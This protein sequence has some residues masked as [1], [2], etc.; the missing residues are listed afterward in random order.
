M[1]INIYQKRNMWEHARRVACVNKT[2]ILIRPL[3]PLLSV[4][5]NL[6]VAAIAVL[7]IVCLVCG[8]CGYRHTYEFLRRHASPLFHVRVCSQEPVLSIPANYEALHHQHS[9]PRNQNLRPLMFSYSDCFLHLDSPPSI[10]LAAS[11]NCNGARCTVHGARCTLR[12]VHLHKH[13]VC[14][15]LQRQHLTGRGIGRGRGREGGR[16]RGREGERERGSEGK[17]GSKR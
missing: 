15:R 9:L 1:V 3:D 7:R 4:R 8:L 12:V 16:E 14:A 13:L 5:T 10:N 11:N 17:T 6:V 2:K